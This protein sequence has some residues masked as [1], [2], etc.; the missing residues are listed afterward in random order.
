MKKILVLISI[1]LFLTACNSKN[2][3]SKN[4][5][6]KTCKVLNVYNWGEYIDETS[7]AKFEDEY[8]VKVNYSLFDSNEA[9]YTKLVASGNYDVVV[10]SDY[11]IER[12]IKENLLTE[13]DKSLI[14]NYNLI[15]KDVLNR[16]FDAN[17][18]Y[19]I[20]YFWGNVGIVYDKTI[21]DPKDVET[22]G[23]DVFKNEKYAGKIYMYD[24]E[25]DSFMIA[26]KALGFS[27]NTENE[28]EIQKAY[29][30]LSEV[31]QK[32][33]PAYATDEAI[34]GLAT[35]EKAMGVMYSGDATTILASN[36]KM[37][38]FV[39]EKGTNYWLDGF[40]IPKTSKCVDLAHKFIDF[41]TSTD[42]SVANST[43]VGYP[44]A[45]K[46]A[47]QIVAEEEYKD[48]IAYLPKPMND[49]DEVFKYNEVLKEKL[50]ELW[51]K[52]KNK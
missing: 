15:S 6:G 45:N 26:F 19:S 20:P 34:D 12:L 10:P 16:P 51:I 1:C 30:W 22:L 41:M 21:I 33:A 4:E 52:I 8:E 2:E 47:L 49:K 11:T 38:Y 25:R 27:M 43:A 23:W 28:E 29:D 35:G 48:N 18:D 39:P 44:S 9:M 42:I 24:S 50:S 5:N 7:L 46:E 31:H 36:P 37:S 3:V 13:L 32:M 17:N 40:A 14:S